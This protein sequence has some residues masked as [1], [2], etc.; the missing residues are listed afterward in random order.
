MEA[1]VLARR[2]V[3]LADSKQANDIIMLD[4][5]PLATFADFLVIC[6][7]GNERMLRA[8]VKEI[9]DQLVQEGAPTPKVEGSPETGWVLLDF[10]DVVVHIFSPEQRDFY[11]L[12]KLWQKATPVVVLQ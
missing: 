9:D 7:A 4:V 3:D 10:G 1:Q 5:R 6:T 11:K 2:A 8:V 12:D